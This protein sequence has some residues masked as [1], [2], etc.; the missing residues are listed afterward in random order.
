MKFH[1]KERPAMNYYAGSPALVFDEFKELSQADQESMWILGLNVKNRVQCKE[2]VALGGLD[3]TCVYPRVIFKRLLM[4]D[5]SSVILVH[6]HP[7]GQVE[8]SNDDIRLTSVIKDGCKVFDIRL[9]DHVII[10]EGT[11]FSF[12]EKNLI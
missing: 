8:P 12:R 6:N 7:S 9:L 11:Y 10:G 4:T 1:I 3:T 2:L 5:S